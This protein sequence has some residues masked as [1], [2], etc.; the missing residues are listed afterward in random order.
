MGVSTKD[1]G[2]DEDVRVAVYRSFAAHGRPPS[3]PEL[4]D[5][6]GG[7]L[8]VAKQALHRLADAHHVVLD[9]CEHVVMAHPFAAM[10]LSFSV[11]GA[12]TLWWG[13]CAWDSFAIPHLVEAEPEVLVATR[14]AGCGDPHAIVVGR[15]AP[16][17]GEQVAHFLVPAGRMWDDVVHTCEHQRL[18]CGESC[19]DDWVAK[20][21]EEK[22]YVMDLTTLWK[23]AAHWYE[24]RLEHGYQRREPSEAAD[25]F[26][27]AGLHGSF[28]GL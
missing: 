10:P 12:N 15:E 3:A 7:S 8:A 6:A 5:A 11:M 20:S 13:G 18:F 17:S 4:A 28:W 21:G 26:S 14:C 25:Y 24:G 9:E 22:G 23:L 1:T 27:G 16:P 2:W 19:V